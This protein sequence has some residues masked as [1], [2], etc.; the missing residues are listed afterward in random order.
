[1]RRVEFAIVALVL[2]VAIGLYAAKYDT[3]HERDR[4]TMSVTIGE[5]RHPVRLGSGAVRHCMR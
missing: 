5:L 3:Q 4:I 1:M 2:I